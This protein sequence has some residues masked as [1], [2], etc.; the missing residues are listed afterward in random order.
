[1]ELT[2]KKINMNRIIACILVLLLFSCKENTVKSIQNDLGD[3]TKQKELIFAMLDSF[4]VAAA[5]ADFDGYFS[6]FASNATFIGTDATEYW[7]KET[8]R[9]WA[10]PYFDQKKT[11]NFKALKRNIYFGKYSDIAWFDEI[12]N[13][14]M[15]I[16][17]GSGILVKQNNNWKVQQY[18]LSMTLPNEK[19]KEVVKIKSSIE[20]SI[21][22]S[23]DK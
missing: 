13:T 15:K 10:K 18:V 19:T 12:L 11:W 9:S 21:I 8:F 22:R 7:T 23:F 6:F 16:C 4:N 5:T 1:M 20:D 14:Q 17:R 2:I 3:I